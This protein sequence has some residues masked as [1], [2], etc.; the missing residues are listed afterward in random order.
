MGHDAL[1]GV[2]E[3]LGG[4]ETHEVVVATLFDF[5]L[6]LH[7]DIRRSFY[8]F[9]ADFGTLAGSPG[10]SFKEFFSFLLAVDAEVFHSLESFL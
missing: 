9:S 6:V 4:A 2:E 3:P 10:S 1:A 7:S 8:R 5:V